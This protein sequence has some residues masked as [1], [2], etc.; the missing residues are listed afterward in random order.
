MVAGV[1][2]TGIFLDPSVAPRIAEHLADGDHVLILGHHG[3]GKSLHARHGSEYHRRVFAEQVVI[4][5]TSRLSVED[6]GRQ[7]SAGGDM[8]VNIDRA[9][10][11]SDEALAAIT[12][13]AR[14][15][16]AR[17]LI[18]VEDRAALPRQLQDLLAT[19]R[20]STITLA[21]M[22]RDE[23]RDWLYAY[24]GGPVPNDLA[25]YVWR[26]TG[27]NAELLLKL[28]ESGRTSGLWVRGT[29]AWR[30]TASIDAPLAAIPDAVVQHVQRQF[31][32]LA[33]RQQ[34]FLLRLA[35]TGS[36]TVPQSAERMSD[37]QIAQLE[38]AG[39]V[40]RTR[41]LDGALVLQLRAAIFGWVIERFAQPGLRRDIFASL[42][43]PL[44]GRED[45]LAVLAWTRLGMRVGAHLTAE[46]IELSNEAALTLMRWEHVEEAV[47]T[48]V[49]AN[50]MDSEIVASILA[51]GEQERSWVVLSL[52]QRALAY[53]FRARH[54][55]AKADIRIV[56]AVADHAPQVLVGIGHH[57]V[58]VEVLLADADGG[59]DLT[60]AAFDRGL[61]HAE[62]LGDAFLIE[63]IR[64]WRMS[65]RSAEPTSACGTRTD[66]YHAPWCHAV[67][68]C[69]R[70]APRPPAGTR[71]SVRGCLRNV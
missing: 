4:G 2:E 65:K 8:I 50:A 61:A 24:L 25:D 53:Y 3:S 32:A 9:A 31:Y 12:V 43:A 26:A 41:R 58:Q 40:L 5:P 69:P 17:L 14:M 56:H 64:T 13:A 15:H 30:W 19:D 55:L 33:E 49:S 63:N 54:T 68:R 16:G 52:M 70:T 6:L 29:Y 27:G 21:P 35:L 1:P 10:R 45:P 71:R 66:G 7:L 28:T 59:G 44:R 38:H 39:F 22:T 23:S 37:A 42:D 67:C 36:M 11:L 34:S 48:L 18:E 47:D 62:R 46:Q 60:E 57:L 51:R 20:Y